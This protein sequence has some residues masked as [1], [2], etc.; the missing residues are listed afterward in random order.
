M[1]TPSS[2]CVSRC[3]TGT[4]ANPTTATPFLSNL[5]LECWERDRDDSDDDVNI[6]RT[7][8]I[9]SSPPAR[10]SSSSS[11]NFHSSSNG[12]SAAV[13]REYSDMKVI[14]S[15]SF[16]T[17]YSAVEVGSGEKVAI[18]VETVGHSHNQLYTEY[19]VYSRYLK[20]A[21]GF[22]RVYRWAHTKR[23]NYM[24][25][26]LLGK[27]LGTLFKRRGHR[28]SCD[29]VCMIAVQVLSRLQSLHEKSGF[30]HRDLKPENILVGRGGGKDQETGMTQLY[31]VDLG[32][33]KPFCRAGRHIDMGWRRHRSLCGTARYASVNAHGSCTM[34]RRDDLENLAYVIIY[35][36]NGELP[37]M[38]IKAATKRQ[39]Y[40]RIFEKK[41]SAKPER[42][43]KGL[44]DVFE[45]Y[46]RYC[47]SLEF[48]ERPNY[49]RWRR[50]FLDAAGD[51][52]VR[53]FFDWEKEE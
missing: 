46:L 30:L 45:R 32:L 19:Q 3:L 9:F 22:A 21:P 2:S 26:E 11:K 42:L 50:E 33:A 6:N 13:R 29:S 53:R 47:K 39:K 43:C 14:G 44:P 16:G 35:L 36:A 1:R 15:G 17:I 27:D 38:G 52:G 12:N 37:W 41:I 18:K 24:V 25:M 23:W 5:V 20:G 51:W 48:A 7:F 31:L 40:E 49:A 4:G 8:G 28:F 34:S 10:K